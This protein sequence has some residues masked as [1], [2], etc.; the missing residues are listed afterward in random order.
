MRYDQQIFDHRGPTI[1]SDP[2]ATERNT[3]FNQVALRRAAN[4]NGGEVQPA[5]AP[6]T[7]T[8]E[9]PTPS[10]AV[11]GVLSWGRAGQIETT[12]GHGD[13]PLMPEGSGVAATV[14]TATTSTEPSPL[15]ARIEPVR[16][17]GASGNQNMS[18]ISDYKIG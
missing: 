9:D 1:D 4:R 15:G 16:S 13:T 14:S 6:P 17:G 8:A 2:G 11:D 5:S 18:S 3:L 12:V 10:R 7:V